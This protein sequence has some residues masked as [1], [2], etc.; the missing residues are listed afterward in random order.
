[1][2]AIKADLTIVADGC[3]SRFRKDLSLSSA[4]VSSRFAGILMCDCP[5]YKPGYAEIILTS[6]GPVLV[7]QI[8]HS[9]T[10]ILID[11]RGKM[12]SNMNQFMMDEI[13]PQ[14]TGIYV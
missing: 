14:L 13:T 8:S 9:D 2:Q 7:Y 10:R 6:H 4:S 5:Q 11:I 3:F 12:P 1:M